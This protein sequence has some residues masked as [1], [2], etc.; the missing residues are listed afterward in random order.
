M[1][2]F[3]TTHFE[4][5]YKKLHTAQ[6][7]VIDTAVAEIIAN[8]LIGLAKKGNLQG[9]RVHKVKVNHQLTLIAY[10]YLETI[11]EIRFISF[12]PHENFYRDLKH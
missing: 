11:E 4:K 12:G 8:P 3:K 5:H 9:I 7:D 1:R 10:R 2:V 6:Q